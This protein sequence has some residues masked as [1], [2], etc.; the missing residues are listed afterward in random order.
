MTAIKFTLTRT[1]FL[2]A[3]SPGI[4]HLSE[5]KAQIDNFELQKQGPQLICHGEMELIIDYLAFSEEQPPPAKRM[6]HTL[7]NDQSL[8][9][10]S[11]PWQAIINIPFELNADYA[12]EYPLKGELIID[13][14][15]WFMISSKAIETEIKLSLK[16]LSSPMLQGMLSCSKQN[17]RKELSGWAQD[18]LDQ[19]IN[20]FWKGE[21]EMKNYRK[22]NLNSRPWQA[23]NID[24]QKAEACNEQDN[25]NAELA[26]GLEELAAGLEQKR[27]GEAELLAGLLALQQGLQNGGMID[28]ETLSGLAELVNGLEQKRL[29]EAE[30][31]A[32]L[33]ELEA[34]LKTDCFTWDR[35]RR[36]CAR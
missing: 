23:A 2:D 12:G 13:E 19:N 3:Q 10:L 36:G 31:L 21:Q 8:P 29:G 32:G 9:Q 28:A 17:I 11:R 24:E 18:D 34:G 1:I 4:G 20:L 33:K 14:I 26:Q 16:A 5:L 27:L 22:N 30:L 15:K 7:S 25:L 35:G 6:R